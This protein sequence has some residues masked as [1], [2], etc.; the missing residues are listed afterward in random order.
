MGLK[1][2]IITDCDAFTRTIQKREVPLRVSRWIIFLQDFDYVIEHRSGNKMKHVDALSRV[3]CLLIED[4]VKHRLREAQLKD[5]WI[6]AV[7]RVLEKEEYQDF[8]VKYDLLFKDSDKE[9]LVVPTDMEE[10]IIR[11]A[12]NQGHF[13]VKRTQDCVEKEFYIP[14]L[15]AK[16]ARVVKSCV[17]CI[18]MENKA[19]KKKVF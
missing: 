11:I 5:E 4:S 10:E 6:K 7:R 12:H 19:G 15:A 16:V 13:A 18:I 14:Q 3:S 17:K 2:K 9:L 1:F 8:Y